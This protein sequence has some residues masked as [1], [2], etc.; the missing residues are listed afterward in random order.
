MATVFGGTA[1]LAFI[2]AP[3]LFQK[4]EPRVAGDAFGLIL[5]RFDRLGLAAA[6]LAT[7]CMGLVLIIGI[8]PAL[9][10]VTF[11]VLSA[12]SLGLFIYSQRSLTPR[13]EKVAPPREQEA[14]D[15]RSEEEKDLF[16]A[17]HKAHVR[18]YASNL[19]LS[20]GALLLVGMAI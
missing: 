16:D 17:L 8:A 18:V 14:E 7:V 9:K 5:S 15:P 3:S 4:L 12:A 13:L 11:L 19:V 1:A 10:T 6:A 20:V 2:T